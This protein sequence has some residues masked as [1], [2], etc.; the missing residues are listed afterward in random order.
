MARRA[1]AVL[2][3]VLITLAAQAAP[4]SAPS[5]PATSP[6]EA[7]AVGYLRT[8]FGAQ[9]EYK[10]KHGAYAKSLASLVGNGSFTRRMATSD[11]GDYTVQFS[12]TGEGFSL[13]MVPKTF[14]AEHRAFFINETGT[15]RVEADKPANPQSPPLK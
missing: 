15:V 10:K 8:V 7:R 12:G 2:A 13:G 11:R 4:Q 5:G 3:A 9:R 14:D 1:A 6:A